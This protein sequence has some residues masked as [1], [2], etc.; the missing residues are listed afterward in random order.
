MFVFI[1]WLLSPLTGCCN[2]FT[3]VH[4]GKK[5][6]KKLKFTNV[7]DYNIKQYPKSGMAHTV[8]PMGR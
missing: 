8:N 7:P 5:K 3:E 4:G 1:Y 6:E 2:C